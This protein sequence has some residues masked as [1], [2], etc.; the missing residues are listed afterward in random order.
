MMIELILFFTL[1]LFASIGI[2]F[3]LSCMRE[4]REESKLKKE[5][6]CKEQFK[7]DVIEVINEIMEEEDE[8]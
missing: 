3:T 7:Q 8:L 2:A 5:L 4:V 1:S 6:L